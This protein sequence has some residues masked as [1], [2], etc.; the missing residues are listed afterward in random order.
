MLEVYFIFPRKD[1]NFEKYKL[2]LEFNLTDL[3]ELYSM[4]VV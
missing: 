4:R 1:L 3:W 2:K